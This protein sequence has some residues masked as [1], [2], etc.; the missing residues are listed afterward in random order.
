MNELKV[1]FSEWRIIANDMEEQKR[2]LVHKRG[3]YR[4]KGKQ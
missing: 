3:S 2:L 1:L 4:E